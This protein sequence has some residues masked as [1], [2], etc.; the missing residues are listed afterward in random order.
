ML[1]AKRFGLRHLFAKSD[2][3]GRKTF[4]LWSHSRGGW[5]IAPRAADKDILLFSLEAITDTPSGQWFTPHGVLARVASDIHASCA[6]SCRRYTLAGISTTDAHRH[7]IGTY[8]L[9]TDEV[10]ARPSYI[11]YGIMWG[12][13]HL[14]FDRKKCRIGQHKL[15]GGGFATVLRARISTA[16]G[17]PCEGWEVSRI[18]ATTHAKVFEGDARLKMWCSQDDCLGAATCGSCT[19]VATCGWCTSNGKCTSA[20]H[21]SA[22]WKQK[23]ASQVRNGMH[24]QPVGVRGKAAPMRLRALHVSG[25]RS[26]A[27]GQSS[28]LALVLVVGLAF[29]LGATIFRNRKGDQAGPTNRRAQMQEP[30]ASAE[31]KRLFDDR[32]AQL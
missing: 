22:D 10:L 20:R 15:P 12:N 24:M 4:L 7:Y 28:R 29:S 3:K 6:G 19:A 8:S 13:K 1:Q 25:T 26:R 23:C 11:K 30:E 17:V 31:N 2:V 27:N 14:F 5:A 9:A 32:N 18:N 21:C 16:V